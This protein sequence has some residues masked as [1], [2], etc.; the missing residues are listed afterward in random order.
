MFYNNTFVGNHDDIIF[1][2]YTEATTLQELKSLIEELTKNLEIYHKYN[3]P[4]ELITPT[5]ERLVEVVKYF[6]SMG[7]TLVE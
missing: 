3:A 2:D 4:E 7:G 5:Q 6:I 1:G